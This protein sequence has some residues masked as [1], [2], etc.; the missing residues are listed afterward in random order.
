MIWAAGREYG[1][2]VE[3]AAALGTDVTER[4]IVNW[5]RRDGLE[6]Q[7]VGRKVYS[8][9]DQAAQ[10]EAQKRLSGRGRPRQ[11]DDPLVPAA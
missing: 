8:P 2:A 7:Q 9:L 3:I 10:I 1:T 6:C 5:R 11:L 4:M